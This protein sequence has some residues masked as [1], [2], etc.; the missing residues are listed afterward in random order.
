[1]KTVAI[2]SLVI[3]STNLVLTGAIAA[4]ALKQT[5]ELQASLDETKTSTAKTI[6]NLGTVLTQFEI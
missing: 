1:M 5:S 2:A 3:S 6:K 4:Y